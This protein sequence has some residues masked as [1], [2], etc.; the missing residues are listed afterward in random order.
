M[1]SVEPTH[2]SAFRSASRA[3]DAAI[4]SVLDGDHRYPSGTT[5]VPADLAATGRVKSYARLGP[6]SIVDADGNETRLPQD[7][8]R[9][10]VLIALLLGVAAWIAARRPS[11]LLR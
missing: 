4:D 3:L 11:A 6:V 5:F 7:R 8:M 2:S 10:I 1:A 9:E